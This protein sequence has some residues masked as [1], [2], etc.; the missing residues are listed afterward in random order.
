MLKLRFTWWIT[1]GVAEINDVCVRLPLGF[2]TT[3]TSQGRYYFESQDFRDGRFFLN[4]RYV[5]KRVSL[6]TFIYLRTNRNMQ[7]IQEIYILM[8]CYSINT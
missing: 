2:L 7:F 3:S 6:F 5:N 4:S 1:V 8:L